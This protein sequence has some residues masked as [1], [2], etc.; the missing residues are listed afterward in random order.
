MGRRL[1][2]LTRVY[3]TT[4]LLFIAAK[5]AFMLFNHEGQD[6]SAG[7]VFDV[8]RHGLTLDLSTALYFLIIPF[9]VILVSIW[10]NPKSRHESSHSDAW[11]RRL[12]L[13]LNIY[14]GIVAVALMMAFVADT[15]LYPFWGFKLDASCLQY[16]ETPEEAGASVSVFYLLIRLV[17]IIIGSF[18]I[19]RLYRIHPIPL[20]SHRSPLTSFLLHLLLIPLFVIGIRGGIDESTTNIGQVYYSQNPFLNHSAVNPVFSFLSSFEKTANAHTVYDFYTDEECQRL[21]AGLFPTESVGN[22]TLLTTD[23]PNIVIILLES[24]SEVFTQAMPHLNSLRKEGIWFTNCYG[25]SYR[26][27]RGTVCTLSGYPSFPTMSVMKMPKKT[28]ALPSIARSLKREGYATTYLY[29]GDINFTNMRSYLIATGWETLHWKADYTAQEQ[30]T[31]K[32]GVR[33]DITFNTLCDMIRNK[34]TANQPFL[35]GFS[36]LSS[37]EPWDVPINELSDE[38][39]NAFRYLDN[40]IGGFVSQLKRTPQW[41]DLLIVM[42]PDHGINYQDIDETRQQRNHI[43]MLWIGGAVKEP[44][45]IPRYCN[46]TDLAATLLGQLHIPHGEFCFSRDVLSTN[47][48]H[49]F[50]FHCFNN[51]FSMIDNDGFTVYDLTSEK[52]ITPHLPSLTPHHIATGKAILQITSKDLQKDK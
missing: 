9:L 23:S 2:Y 26:T 33:D 20:T 36:T 28:A 11:K 18:L 12:Q 48:T 32:W 5:V 38:K 25:N 1:L 24:C 16:L 37:H 6:F 31:A 43:P 45:E 44:R 27:D 29:G 42:L 30:S 39:L 21:T 17:V 14:Y 3:L 41:K 52:A 34:A 40:C 47:Y 10:T 22:D 7:D 19:Y 4:V 50:A 46:Q 8:V 51:G 15:S 13:V 49:P 35:I